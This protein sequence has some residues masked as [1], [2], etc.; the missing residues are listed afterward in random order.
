M[1]ASS[2]TASPA[3]T[4]T[5]DYW[6]RSSCAAPLV[7]P[8]QDPGVIG[9]LRVL[10]FVREPRGYMTGLHLIPVCRMRG[11]QCY[12]QKLITRTIGRS[13]RRVS[14]VHS[15]FD[16]KLDGFAASDPS[17]LFSTKAVPGWKSIPD[18]AHLLDLDCW[19]GMVPLHLRYLLI[20]HMG[21]TFPDVLR[22]WR[23][24]VH[25]IHWL[26]R[27]PRIRIKVGGFYL[28]RAFLPR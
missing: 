21:R 4:G 9:T 5:A 18:G 27:L 16:A 28:Q 26:I 25:Y 23:S 17:F 11:Y 10:P 13:Q 3:T 8:I 2:N 6:N 12:K 19:A 22:S 20:V 7:S 15:G 1:S 24:N 14:Q